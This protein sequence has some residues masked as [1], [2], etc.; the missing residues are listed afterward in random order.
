M[1]HQP[2]DSLSFHPEEQSLGGVGDA[3][4]LDIRH[5]IM[6]ADF[7][8]GQFFLASTMA[9]ERGIDA[10]LMASV[11]RALQC[12]GY[13]TDLGSGKYKVKGWSQAEFQNALVQ[14]QD[15][16]RSVAVK[17]AQR[18]PDADHA[19]LAACLDVEVNHNPS[20]TDVEAYYIRWWMFFQCSLHA[21]GMQSFRTFT[22]T[23]TPPYLRRRLLT[24][25]TPEMIVMTFASLRKLLGA[26]NLHAGDKI[27]PLME[28]YSA[29]I[30]PILIATNDLYNEF[31]SSSEIDY[32]MPAISGKPLFRKAGDSRPDIARGFRE[33]LNWEQFK[34]LGFRVRC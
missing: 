26:Y 9:A 8:P 4:F 23:V 6:T 14:M 16:Q 30:F 29:K 33:P 28:E 27:A 31:M 13:V 2:I 34:A 3:L 17:Y 32:R 19:R 20:P 22:L 12:H 21:Y 25:F 5:R 15:S 18:M 7:G 11:G 24:G 1:L 10:E